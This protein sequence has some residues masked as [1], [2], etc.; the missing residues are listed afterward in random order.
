MK[1]IS[2]TCIAE[3]CTCKDRPGGAV[4]V[5]KQREK[6][7]KEKINTEICKFE[8]IDYGMFSFTLTD[9]YCF[10]FLFYIFIISLFY[11]RSVF[12]SAKERERGGRGGW[13][14]GVCTL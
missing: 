6:T 5:K 1:E 13:H 14:E 10:Y 2:D 11:T 9:F 3:G 7:K 12:G 8:S 4:C